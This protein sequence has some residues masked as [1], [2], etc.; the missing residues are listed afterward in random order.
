MNPELTR[1]LLDS[2]YRAQMAFFTLPPLPEG[3]TPQYVHIIDAITHIEQEKGKVR[4]SD[5]AEWFHMSVPG[6]TRSIHALEK[7]GAVKK[8]RD[9]NDRRV[10]LIALTDQGRKW[11]DTYLEEYHQ[12]LSELLAEIPESD[13]E[14]TILT[15]PRVVQLMRDHPITLTEQS[16]KMNT[17]GGVDNI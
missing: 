14:T 12:K 5:V 15:I 8:I 3:L 10:V 2:F 9:D 4:V 11:Y 16:T 1:K 6:V 7:I 17:S 13:V